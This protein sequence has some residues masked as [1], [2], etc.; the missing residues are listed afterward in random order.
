M[1]P[2]SYNGFNQVNTPAIKI[3][4]EV[5]SNLW[6]AY[7]MPDQPTWLPELKILRNALEYTV[8]KQHFKAEITDSTLK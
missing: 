3:H 4:Q 2:K 8:G 6:L 7:I 1:I 5:R